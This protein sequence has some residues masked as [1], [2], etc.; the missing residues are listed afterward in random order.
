MALK[1]LNL[2]IYYQAM[3][4]QCL[5]L[6]FILTINAC[7][8]QINKAE[9]LKS[10]IQ[11]VNVPIVEK[12][13]I[14]KNGEPTNRKEFYL[15]MSIKDYYIKFCESKVKE[16]DLKERLDRQTGSIK[17]LKLEVEFKTG[18]WDRCGEEAVQSRV[19]DYVLIHRIQ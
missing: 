10:N 11:I 9:K 6:I 7:S 12:P 14:K 16:A 2:L 1:K 13:F 4:N 18:E 5:Y 3:K 8:V 17:T 15:Q 19:G